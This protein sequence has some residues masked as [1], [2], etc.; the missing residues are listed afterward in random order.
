MFNMN[1]IVA[2]AQSVRVDLQDFDENIRQFIVAVAKQAVNIANDRHEVVKHL[3]TIGKALPAS[4]C[5]TSDK[6]VDFPRSF[7]VKEKEKKEAKSSDLSAADN[8]SSESPN[9]N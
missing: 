2:Y 8:D 4:G 6:P 7:P 9:D 5:K 3:K 1:G